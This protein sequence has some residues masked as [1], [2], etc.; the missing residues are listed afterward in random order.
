MVAFF[1]S[2][3]SDPTPTVIEALDQLHLNIDQI[4]ANISPASLLKWNAPAVL[5][6]EEAKAKFCEEMGRAKKYYHP[7]LPLSTCR[8]EFPKTYDHQG[9]E[10][11]QSTDSS[12]NME[13]DNSFS[14]TF[15]IDS[16]W[17]SD[18]TDFAMDSISSSRTSSISSSAKHKE[19]E[20]VF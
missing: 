11:K 20:L 14:N 5:A 8:S 6:E 9:M 3:F 17:L 15:K 18:A 13:V 1:I 4:K 19:G 16:Q 7:T 12:S 10:I 2:K